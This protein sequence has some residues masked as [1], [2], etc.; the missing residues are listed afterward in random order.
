MWLEQKQKRPLG[1]FFIVV[2]FKVLQSEL[3][4]YW[5]WRQGL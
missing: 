5:R 3:G 2:V 4:N 1:A